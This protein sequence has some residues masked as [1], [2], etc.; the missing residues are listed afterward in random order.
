MRIQLY[1]S[2]LSLI[3]VANYCKNLKMMN[4][5]RC[6]KLTDDGIIVIAINCFKLEKIKFSNENLTDNS[7]FEISKNCSNLK[8]LYLRGCKNFTDIGWY[9]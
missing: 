6:E 1:L 7:L 4:F 3:A 8:M 9:N 2:D 5:K